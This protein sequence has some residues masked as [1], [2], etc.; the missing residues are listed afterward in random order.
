VEACEVPFLLSEGNIKERV[1]L[2]ILKRF[3]RSNGQTVKKLKGS[4]GLG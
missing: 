4:E 1:L 2:K 3:K